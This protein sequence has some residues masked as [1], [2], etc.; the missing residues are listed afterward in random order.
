MYLSL[1]VPS[2]RI[3]VFRAAAAALLA[4]A[5]IISLILLISPV[6]ELEAEINSFRLSG[7]GPAARSSAGS[8]ADPTP[9]PSPTVAALS[10]P[11]LTAQ[12]SEDGVE[13]SWT[14][15]HG[16]TRYELF[17]WDSVNEW[18][19]IGGDSL[20]GT[21]YTYTD[22]VA[23]ATYFYII[24]A[25][26]ADG[27]TSAWSDQV[28]TV[29]ATATAT[30]T[31]TV[32]P[33]HTPAATATPT[34]TPAAT[35]TPTH[36][37]P[38]TVTPTH[39]NP[40]AT[41]TPTHT[42]AATVTPTHTPAATVTPTHTP[43]ATATP[44]HTPPA[45]VTATHTPAA[46]VT[47]TLTPTAT[48]GQP[49]DSSQNDVTVKDDSGNEGNVSPGQTS[50]DKTRT[51][52]RQGLSGPTVSITG[53]DGVVVVGGEN[54]VNGASFNVTIT[55]S[56][57]VGATFDHTDITVTNAQT[58]AATDVSAS[59]AG[60]IYIATVRPTA[61][62][63]GTVTVQVPA[64]AAQ[65][66]SNE[67]NQASNV[68][69]VTATHTPAAT[70]TSTNTPTATAASTLPASATATPTAT[71]LPA[72]DLTV[73]SESA[74]AI[75][76][77]WTEVS[78]AV[79]Y[80][81]RA[82][83]AEEGWTYFDDTAAGVTTFTHRGLVAGREYYY[84][85]RGVPAE[86]KKG[87]WSVRQDTTASDV[88][89]T[90]TAT[91]TP[92]AT[93][94]HTP[95]ATATHTPT[96]TATHT[97]TATTAPPS[98]S[99]QNGVTVKDD[100]GNEGN[101]SPGQTS[102]DKTRTEPRQGVTGPTV[103]IAGAEGIVVVGGDNQFNGASFDVTI[104]FSENVGATFVNTDITVTNAQS[105]TATDVNAST[106][107]LI[108]TATIRPTAGFS[109]A[110][111]V[112]VPA[113]AAQNASNEGNQASNVFR[114]T[115]TMQSACVTGGAV[116]AGDEYAELARDC[117]TL[118]G[119]HDE[120][121]G[122]ATLSPAWSVSTDIDSWQGINLEAMRVSHLQLERKGLT[123]SLPAALGD[124]DGL[125]QLS[126]LDNTLTGEIPSELGSLSELNWLA[127]SSNQLSGVI[128][129]ELGALVK[130]D[131]LQ[132]QS[133]SLTGP[134]PPE[135][136]RLVK[137]IELHLSSNQLNGPIPP[138]LGDLSALE[139]LVIG[140]NQYESPLPAT[141]TNL[142]GLTYLDVR[143]GKLTGTLP[144]LGQMTSLQ[145]VYLQENLLTGTIPESVTRL[146]SLK[147]LILSSNQLTGSILDFSGMMSLRSLVLDGNQLEGTVP[148]PVSDL[149]NLEEYV[150]HANKFTGSIPTMSSVPKLRQA[151]FHCNQF[152]GEIPASFNNITSLTTLVFF[153]NQLT[154]EIPNLSSLVNLVLL[155]LNHNH[156]EGNIPNTLTAKLPVN[157]NPA[158]KVT[159]NG[160]LFEGVDRKSGAIDSS[161]TGLTVGRRDPCTPRA[162]F[163]ARTFSV[164]EGEVVTVTVSLELAAV[165]AVTIPIAVTHNGGASAADYS[166]EP[167]SSSL[168][169]DIGEVSKPFTITATDDSD[170]DDGESLTLR[171]GTLPAGVNAGGP[172]TATVNITDNDLPSVTV[173]YEQGSYTVGEGSSEVIKVILSADPE[174]SVTIPISRT[175]QGGAT[176][177]DYSGVGANASVTFNSGDTE[178]SITFT[179]TND[180]VDDDDESV[181]LGFGTLPTGVSAGSPA[182]ATVNITDDDVPAVTVR[183][184]QASY[185]VGE[186]SSVVV[187]VIL[188]ADPERTVT[189]PISRTNQGGAT[190][191]DY[192]GVAANASVTFNSGDTE[193]SI[194]FAATDDSDNDDGESVLLSFGTLPT[195]VSLGTNGE[196]TVNITDDDVPSVTVRYEQSSYTVGE[197][198]SEVIKVILSADPERSVTVPI[199][200]TNQGGATDGDYSGVAANTSVTFNSGDTEKSIT[201][202]ATDDSVDDDGESVLLGFGTLP[203]GVSAGSP[204][205]AT[206]N[207]T[208]NDVPAVTVRYEQGSYTVG[209]GSSEVIKVILSADP[210][211]SVTVPIS[212]TNQDGATD[213]DYSGVAAN[214]SVTFNSGDTEKSITFAATD[215]SVDDDGE[216][217]LLS[218]GTLPA[219]VSAGSP[220]TATV[221]ITDNDVPSVTV[222]YEQATYTVGEGNSVVVKV[223]LSADPE[224]T[225]TIPISRT[226][227]GGA[228]D[229]DYSGVA[230]NASVTFNSG[231]TEKSITFAATDDS[232]NDDGESVL[233]SF[234]TLPT[235]VSAGS[236]AMATVNITDDDV[237]AVTVRYEQA[238]YTVGEGS[239][240]VIKVILSA[241]PER[242]VTVPISRTNQGG[243]TDGDY[244]GVAANASV[245]FNSGDTE[246]SITFAAT[247]DS[248][249]DDG[250]SVLL[251]FGTLPTG[252][253]AGSPAMAT[254]NITDDDVPAVTVRYEQAIYTVGEGSSEVIK[255]ILSADP[256]RSVTVPINKANQGGATDGDYSGVAA[257]TSVTFN[258]GEMEKSITFTATDDSV[259]DDDESV[260]LG[261]GTLPT[262]VS[263]GSP[264]TATVNI[265][266]NDVPAVT[267]RYEQGSYTV[268]EGSSVVIKVILSADPERSVTIPISRTNQGGATDG[269]YSGVGANASVTFNSGDTEKSITFAA[270]DDSVDDDG[271]SV[272]LG[273]GTLPTGVSLGINGES[274]V[275]ITDDDVPSVTVR[276]EQGS[277]TVGE[278]SSVVVKV[279]LSAV[280]ER[281]VT[282]PISRTNQDGATDGDYSGVAA[283]ASVTFNSGDTEKSITF[284]A[285]D[286][287][288]DDDGESVL[289]GFG[290]LP[291]GVSLGTNG[292][293]TVNIT[294]DDVPSVTVRYE[295]ASYTVGE[296][297]SVVI[298]VILSAVP[299]RSVTV[300]ISRTNQGGA[301]DGDY[302]GVAANT[303]VTFNSGDTEK[304]ITF[305]ATDDSVDDDGESVLL[306]FG[307][308]P[309]GVSA[310]SPAMA[311]V[312][313]TDDDVPSVTVRY[314]QA[315][316]T[317]G[318]GNSVVIKVIL[319]AD[320][321]RSVTIPISR[322]NQ[323]GATDGDYSGVAANTSVT[324]NSGET[325]KSITFA[326][327]D[328]SVDDDDESVLLSFG[329]L[330]TGVSA[331]SPATATVNITDDDVPSVTVR[332]EQ[333]TYTV[334]EGSSE[335]I[336]VILSADPE[337]TVTVPIS[338]TNQ[339]GASDG[340]YSGVA[341]NASVTFNSGDTEKSI[342][343]T[344]TDDSVDDDGESVLL[345]FG[346]LPTGVSLGTNGESTVNITDDDVPS[347]TVRYEQ[348]SYTV[349]E[350][351]SVDVKVILSAV[352]ERSVTIPI[353]RTN[354]GGATDGDYSGVAANTSVTFNSGDTE[355]SITFAATDDSVDDDGESV[356]L[357]FGTLPT[358]VS[359]GINGESTVNITDNDVRAVTV[360][361]EQASYTVG[362][363]S[364]EVIKVI[365]SA[366]P[367]RSVT[368]PINRT[369]Q[370]GASNGDYS[371]VAADQSDVQQRRHREEHYVY[372]DRRQCGR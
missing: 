173:R 46:T 275:N 104:T 171:F 353:S 123:G 364:S 67:G 298:K 54:Q 183:Y 302:S 294:D 241:D 324:F 243:A 308:L 76:L 146:G 107:G 158:L 70:A 79:R 29:T 114:A 55:F 27:E 313:I 38:A 44:T 52:P 170:N 87:L 345:G 343:F 212:R 300:P 115:A 63:S 74:D 362:E 363:G 25:A 310:G 327:T 161:P 334:G 34:H 319:S 147:W 81:P 330:P 358:G 179:A 219:G 61:G 247:D 356:L 186:G 160:N 290:T 31:A 370:D 111:T 15:V 4:A 83:T 144:D 190:D 101:V 301:T 142:T 30:A 296:G 348:A 312:N 58:L 208:D 284:A 129:S 352:P 305:A 36:T 97:P 68:F 125:T 261:F 112:Q 16:A 108:Y 120:L 159:L 126:L 6:Q 221:N 10:V 217:V 231:D 116:S 88:Q 3:D 165:E 1:S 166:L 184:E 232:D 26:N 349:G 240:E 322:T 354:Q 195:G 341:A 254:V 14:T 257:N 286:D 182:T 138:E 197:G 372:G 320:P 265:T 82:Y 292:E 329:T 109:G 225:V 252:V 37:P 135:I 162:G 128:P 180:S 224:R 154:G 19:P 92:A 150:I 39:H 335:V 244:S 113:A 262:G 249:N 255:V 336:K 137:L 64:D 280:P 140:K 71:V 328:D 211:R 226:N 357:G 259:D 139:S 216:S 156:L 291:T 177:G 145:Y 200:R 309:T 295:Q 228:T 35:V 69:S 141:L 66:A 267:V 192:S 365:L 234:G 342:T 65:N 127:L 72:P 57:N 222:R 84:W 11:V 75:E 117:A 239:S 18:R 323:G 337:R 223:I 299:E 331:G 78:G 91:H 340:D 136:G 62:F 100:S 251:S 148:S 17:V 237:P 297:S 42:P 332:Y 250:E 48:T 134:I 260:L 326:A 32:T 90:A 318:E 288:V 346:T 271:E 279:I 181:L 98:D 102:E 209:E 105:L 238:I 220:A 230:A 270:T 96:A 325:E 213:G 307:T 278:G 333:A 24:R 347:V 218:F 368:I 155:F 188:S 206:V 99:S 360:R 157:N 40:A 149:P 89:P 203:A 235:G 236:P 164:T 21:T 293:S 86:G 248:D 344:A 2:D 282:V 191:G 229:G 122:S 47:P 153:D 56:E 205:T 85:V 269:D 196:S 118:L 9:T 50:E 163:D 193:K 306:S 41:V 215:D 369:N 283:N 132:L 199:S 121:V 73:V 207:I 268:G 59:T 202:A 43:A 151:W 371:G 174:R 49:S 204:A 366:D 103:T 194:T 321:E 214:A 245:T 28:S 210:E 289:L 80:E 178:K 316:Y 95:A 152:S 106:A 272:L 33:T 285:T 175:N 23:G 277:Y 172:A 60:L 317:V 287:S 367:E 201:F 51:E 5:A 8:A 131:Y 258:S 350:G 276:Y 20:T 315:T 266:D 273:F 187:K 133:N 311:T 198:N 94:T 22:L 124:L 13:L 361:Y 274:T 242:S 119:L 77:S 227:Q 167:A 233:L 185:T 189:V 304:S 303:S 12:A 7:G 339:D 93:T 338:R 355:K 351:N 359:L 264:A 263:A 281:S 45:T 110:V 314:E 169:F 176:D 130:L 246:K 143:E 253:S 53:G 256:E 168:T